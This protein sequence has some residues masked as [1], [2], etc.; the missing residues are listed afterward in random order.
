MLK[1]GNEYSTRFFRI[2]LKSIFDEELFR[3]FL[4]LNLKENLSVCLYLKLFHR[5]SDKKKENFYPEYPGLLR[6]DVHQYFPQNQ[7]PFRIQFY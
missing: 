7:D 1:S 6:M 5:N 3:L 2:I 4:H